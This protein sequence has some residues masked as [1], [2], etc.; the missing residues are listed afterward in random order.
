MEGLDWSFQPFQCGCM[1][2]VGLSGPFQWEQKSC[3]HLLT[4]AVHIIDFFC[5]FVSIAEMKIQRGKKSFVWTQLNWGLFPLQRESPAPKRA[6]SNSFLFGK[7]NVSTRSTCEESC[8]CAGLS[9]QTNCGRQNCHPLMPVV[10][11]LGNISSRKQTPSIPSF[12]SGGLDSS[13]SPR[14]HAWSLCAV[15]DS[16]SE[17]VLS[18]SHWQCSKLERCCGLLSILG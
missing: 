4:W 13:L 17:D 1:C 14:S 16:Q 6:V 10:P 3:L 9:F 15:L 18:L 2:E 8:G 5:C 11:D 12:A 7:W